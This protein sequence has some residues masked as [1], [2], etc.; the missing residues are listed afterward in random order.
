MPDELHKKFGTTT[1]PDVGIEAVSVFPHCPFCSFCSVDEQWC[2]A[3]ECM[4][5]V[6]STLFESAPTYM[7]T[8]YLQSGVPSCYFE[9]GLGYLATLT[10]PAKVVTGG[11]CH[12]GDC[13]RVLGRSVAS[14]C[15]G[16][17]DRW[18]S[19]MPRAGSPNWS[20]L[21]VLPRT[22]LTCLM[23]SSTVCAR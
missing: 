7:Q 8:Q 15:L 2:C 6:C 16:K 12:W 21:P 9:R 17:C 18:A 14:I 22:P 3:Q 1:A 19:T 13:K 23:R 5:M 11:S 4:P 10:C 20:R